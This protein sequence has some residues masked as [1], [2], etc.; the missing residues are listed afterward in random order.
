W[1][2]S[3]SWGG[4]SDEERHRALSPRNNEAARDARTSPQTTRDQRDAFL[5]NLLLASPPPKTIR[6]VEL[7]DSALRTVSPRATLSPGGRCEKQP[8]DLAPAPWSGV[9]IP[10]SLGDIAGA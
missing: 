1:Q 2:F 10:F 6:G 9:S 7:A 5:A 8:P 4:A 3:L